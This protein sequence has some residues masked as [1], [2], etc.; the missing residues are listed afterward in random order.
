[1]TIEINKTEQKV[2]DKIAPVRDA[3]Q[4]YMN[5]NITSYE[6][7]L[8]SGKIYEAMG[9]AVKDIDQQDF[10]L[11]LSMSVKKHLIVGF[12]G[13]KGKYGGYCPIDS[14]NPAKAANG[15]EEPAHSTRRI[16]LGNGASLVSYDQ[17]NW[18]LEG[19]GIKR[20]WPSLDK[21]CV[22]VSKI[23]LEAEVK[24]SIEGGV[25]LTDLVGVIQDAE[26][27]VT[28]LLTEVTAS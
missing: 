23:M 12:R 24:K 16:N 14:V 9:D 6:G 13:V 22:A 18:C 17:L 8:T 3:V 5:N 28:R 26:M 4:E 25:D 11:G 1:M 21:A 15:E 19:L 20:Y 27:N 7:R 2:A 10:Q